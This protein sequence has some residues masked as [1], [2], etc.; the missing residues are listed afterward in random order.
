MPDGI[1]ARHFD[2]SGGVLRGF[3]PIA[4]L[5]ALLLAAL[6]G[7]FGGTPDPRVTAEGNGARLTVEG[8]RTLRSGMML[9][10]DIIV[11]AARPI[12][13]PVVAISGSYLRHLSF[14]SVIPAASEAKFENGTVMLSYGE[15][16][17]GDRLQVKMDGQVNPS[18]VG[19][20]AGEVA[21][22]DDKTVLAV[23]PVSLRVF[24]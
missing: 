21:I 19:E 14:N 13:N 6:L 1:A 20:N 12:A 5:G 17:A 3:V 18:L 15:L 23:R 8:P 24:P 7:A 22:L 11:D 10:I 9:E 2:S 4:V 16:K